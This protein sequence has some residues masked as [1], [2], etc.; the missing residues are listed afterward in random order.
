MLDLSLEVDS[1]VERVA[2]G[3]L[4]DFFDD[5]GVDDFTVHDLVVDEVLIDLH[6]LE[7]LQ[8]GHVNRDPEGLFN[9]FL[10][11]ALLQEV[12]LEEDGEGLQPQDGVDG[13]HAGADLLVEALG[14]HVVDDEVLGVVHVG[15]PAQ[16]ILPHRL[17]RVL[18]SRFI[19]QVV[20]LFRSLGS[21]HQVDHSVVALLVHLLLGKTHLI[22]NQLPSLLRNIRLPIHQPSVTDY[23]HVGGLVE[24]LGEL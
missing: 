8:I 19:Y 6:R 17:L 11:L 13:V 7:A 1:E 14:D 21:R 12:L 22:L 9:L 18:I 24:L 3:V 15:L 4:V 20:E 2:G 5:A 10:S 16:Q 23:Y